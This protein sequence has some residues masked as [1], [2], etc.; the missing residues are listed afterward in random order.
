MRFNNKTNTA[1]W[2]SEGERI[3]TS[4]KKVLNNP[5]VNVIGLDGKF[6]D[7]FT[8]PKQFY[9]SSNESGPRQ[10]GVF[11][12]LA[13]N[14][15]FS[16]MYVSVEEPLYQDGPRAG[17]K[18]TNAWTRIIQYNLKT[19]RPEKQYAYKLDPIAFTPNPATAFK[20]NGI[21]DI[22][23]VGNNELMVIERSFSTG[24]LACTIKVF[25][26]E[27]DDATDISKTESLIANP[28]VNP[29]KKKLLLNMDTLGIYTDN[30]EGVTFGATLPNGH[31]TLVFVSD[32]NFS[33][34]QT[35]QFLLFEV[36]P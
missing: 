34:V 7:T 18:D 1:V 19:K 2:T 21:P 30:I 13:F 33:P 32:N 15:D 12:G 29:V 26:A 20:V 3:V 31:K 14:D 36:I 11:E 5:S 27:L 9:M 6:V 16:R 28:P 35:T 23:T 25:I 10:N 17:L 8:I 22:L 4:E 24:R